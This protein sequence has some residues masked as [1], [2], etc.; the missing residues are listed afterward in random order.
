MSSVETSLSKNSDTSQDE[1]CMPED[2]VDP[3]ET[4]KILKLLRATRVE[5][6]GAKH[7]LSK[8]QKL[9]PAHHAPYNATRLSEGETEA[10]IYAMGD[11]EIGR[12]EA[13]PVWV[14]EEPPFPP[15]SGELIGLVSLTPF[16]IGFRA[17]LL[18]Y[19]FEHQFSRFC[20]LHGLDYQIHEDFVCLGSIEKEKAILRLASSK[21]FE[22]PWY[23]YHALR[24]L[25]AIDLDPALQGWDSKVEWKA[26]KAILA[27]FAGRLG[28][29]VEQYHWKFRY[30]ADAVRGQK[31]RKA[32]SRS[33]NLRAQRF[34]NE[35]ARWQRKANDIAVQRPKLGKMALAAAVK[36]SLKLIHTP[37]HISRFIKVP[38][39]K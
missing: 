19:F 20:V 10:L 7:E 11:S 9:L 12:N 1:E 6:A 22:K 27:E 28:R 21:T 14:L 3:Y 37:K 35:Q 39:K 36:K 29:L 5:P 26:A 8:L 18:K 15:L 31:I 17:D 33:G 25:D 30:E 38:P 23:E 16:H 24:L 34:K 32:A 2:D 13:A 4:S